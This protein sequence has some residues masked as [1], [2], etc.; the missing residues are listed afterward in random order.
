MID[1]IT[2]L[3]AGAFFILGAAA[4]F[5][6]RRKAAFARVQR[7]YAAS[8]PLVRQTYGSPFDAGTRHTNG[9]L[10]PHIC[11]FNPCPHER[12]EADRRE[13]NLRVMKGGLA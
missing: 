9:K 12:A 2:G 1:F 11:S 4:A 10:A 6:L 7:T 13:R 8:Q 5:R 3:V